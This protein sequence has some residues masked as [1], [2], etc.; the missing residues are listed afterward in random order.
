MKHFYR[1]F[2]LTLTVL[3]FHQETTAQCDCAASDYASINVAGWVVGQTG[4]I[5]TCQWGEERST[6]YN[7]VAG[8]VYRVF[9]CGDGD[10]DTQL[11]IYTTGCGYIGY[12]DDYCGL[13]SQVTFTS[14]GGN[15]YSVLNRYY[16]GSQTTC[17]TVQIQLIS[18]PTPPCTVQGNPAVFGSNTWNVY[19]YDGNNFNTYQGYY[20]EGNLSFNTA[21]RWGTGG[22]PSSASGYQ[23]CPVGND[24]H[25]YIH[26]R[27]GFPAGFYTIDIGRDDDYFLYVNGSLIYSGGCCGTDYGIWSGYLDASS[28]VEIRFREYGG[29]SYGAAT[30]NNWL[31]AGTLYSPAN[32]TT[33]TG[34]IYDYMGP[35][36][37]Y[38]NGSN[39]YTII[40]PTTAGG[41]VILSGNVNTEA[42]CD[43][44]YIYNGQGTGGTLLWS[45][46][47]NQTVP[48][49]I[50]TD[51][52]GALTVRFY[53]DGSVT[54]PGFALNINCCTPAGDQV[55]YGNN[56]W[57]FYCY[58]QTNFTEY[59]GYITE[60]ATFYE[61]FGGADDATSFNTNGCPVTRSNFSVR[62]RMTYNFPCGIYTFR[63]GGDDGHRLYLDGSL[64]IDSYVPQGYTDHYSAPI[65]LSGN[66]NLEI[67]YYEN[68][69]G[70]AVGF[71]WTTTTPTVSVGITQGASGVQCEGT[72]L[73]LSA[74]G[75]VNY[76][77]TP[78]YSWS[79][80]G[81]YTASGASISRTNAPAGTYTVTATHAC[82]QSASSSYVYSTRPSTPA[83]T[84][85]S[86][87]A[88]ICAGQSTTLYADG[89]LKAYY[90]FSSNYND[91]SGNGLHI[92]GGSGGTISAGSWQQVV[93]GARTTASTNIL[94][95]DKYTIEF[96]M[97]FTTASDGSWRKIFGF[98]PSGTDRSPGI[99][100]YPNSQQ[101]HWRHDPGNT[102]INEAFIYN[103]GQWYNVVGEKNGST[104]TLY[105]DGVQV[106]QG[107]VAN[108]KTVGLSSLWFGGA[109][110]RIKEFKVYSGVIRWYSGSCGGTYAGA[111]PQ[112]FVSPSSTTTYYVRV[113]GECNTSSCASQTVTVNTAPVAF[114]GNDRSQC[115]NAAYQITDATVNGSGS[116]NNWT[117]VVNSG[118]VSSVSGTNS[119]TPTITPSSAT[120]QVTMTLNVNGTG[121]CSNTSDVM[122]F[123]WAN[124]PTAN[125]GADIIQ[126]GNASVPFSGSS[127]SSP[128]TF[129]WTVLGGGSGS[130]TVTAFQ[131]GGA[132]TT[133]WR[134]NPTTASGS[135]TVRLSVT[136]TGLCSGSTVT[137]DIT[138]TW[139]EIPSVSTSAT[140]TSCTGDSPIV[141]SGASAGGTYSALSWTLTANSGA[142]SITAN[143]GTVSPT[144]TPD[145]DSTSG[146]YILT[147][148]ALG[149]GGCVGINP[150]SSTLLTWGEPPIAN[151]GSDIITCEG[152]SVTMTGST[153]SGGAHSGVIWVQT[154][155]TASGSFTTTD[156]IDP[157]LW[158]FTPTSSGT[159]TFELQ[160]TGSGAACASTIAT[161][162]RIVTWN[163][164]PTVNA[165]SDLNI[166]YSS[167][168][169]TMSG[170][171]GTNYSSYSWSGG[172][173]IF[174]SWNQAGN[175][176][177]ANFTPI[178][179]S[180]SFLAQVS[181]NGTGA[182]SAEV[183]TD[184]RLV[185]WSES[186]SAIAGT[187]TTTCGNAPHFMAGA[188]A[189]G[190]FSTVSWSGN[191]N[192][193]WTTTHATDPAQWVWTPTTSSGSFTS[194]LTVTG[195]GACA[196]TNPTVTRLI[197]WDAA[198]SVD[199]GTDINVCSSNG[200]ISMSG[201]STANINSYNWSNLN[202]ADGSWNQ[203]GS[204]PLA[205]FTPL[206]GSG[207]IL[208]TLT[209][210]GVGA[211]SALTF[212]DSRILTWNTPPVITSV[213]S[214]NVTDC[215]NDNGVI[216]INSTGES[217]F[218]Y[219]YDNGSTYIAFNTRTDLGAGNYNLV[220]MDN[221]GCTTSYPSNPVVI[222]PPSL[223]V[224]S[225]S[226]VNAQC[227][228]A[229]DGTI[230]VTIT[231]GGTAR[232]TIDVISSV[233]TY[234]DTTDAIGETATLN[235]IAGS[236]NITITDRFGCTTSVG[237][238]V[239][240]EPPAISIST[241]VVNNTNCTGTDGSITVNASGGTPGF[242]FSFDGGAFSATN[243]FTNLSTGDYPIIVRDNND[244][245]IP[246]EESIGGPF[247]ANA[248]LDRYICSGASFQMN[249]Q[250][251]V[252]AVTIAG[253]GGWNY[254]LSSIAYNPRTPGSWT[255]IS[256][257]DDQVSTAVAI[258]FPFT[259][260]GN[261]YTNLYVSSNGFL[262]F[263]N[264]G[265][266][267]C[268][269]GQ[270]LPNAG[271]P[272]NL[273][274]LCWEDLNPGYGGTIRYGVYGSSPNQVFVLEYNNIQHYGGGNPVT[275]QI[276]LF[277]S[278]NN[279][280]IHNTSVPTDG[281]NGHTQGI[282]NAVGDVSTTSHNSQG[283]WTETNS[284]YL[285]QPPYDLT[286][287]NYTWSPST[288]LSNPNILNPT[289]SGLTSDQTYTLQVEMVGLCTIV[290]DMTVHV[291]DLASE[292]SGT[293]GTSPNIST[294]TN[295][296]CNGDDDGCITVTPTSGEGPYLLEG[297]NGEV[298]VYGGRM[299]EVTISN[300]TGTTLTDYQ[301]QINISYT[302]AMRAD[303]GDIRFYDGTSGN[304][305]SLL[306]YY[307]ESYSLSS[308]ANVFVKLPSI[309]NGGTTVYMVYGN[310][311]LVSQSDPDNTFWWYEDMMVTPT[312]TMVNNA[313]YIDHQFVRLTQAVNSASGQLRLISDISSGGDGF[314]ADFEFWIGGGDGADG[315]WL[316]S[317]G[318]DP[319][320]GYIGEDGN[321]NGYAFVFDTW[322]PGGNAN[323]G[324]F[325]VKK[326]GANYAT[327]DY[328]QFDNS[329]W[330][331][332]KVEQF[333][334]TGRMSLDGT[335]YVNYTGLPTDNVGNY[336]GFAA[337]TGGANNEHRIRNIRVR[338]RANPEPTATF[339]TEQLPDN[340]FC[341]LAPGSYSISIWDIAECT[342][343][344]INIPITEPTQ[345][346][347]D[348]ID[349]TDTWCY[350]TNNGQ[351]D[352]TVSG[353]TQISPPPPYLYNWAGPSGFTSTNEDLTGLISGTYNVTV[354]DD[355][356]CTASS[357]AVVNTATP[358]S[359]PSFT[360]T[361]MTDQLWQDP[362]NWDCGVPDATSDVIIPATPIGGNT[363][364]IT[365][366]IIGDVFHI[367]VMG[368]IADLLKIDS[369][370]GSKLR[371]HEP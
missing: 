154:G 318:D 107:T 42:C 238:Y 165:S 173:P 243:S 133:D 332:A 146:E 131:N 17:M 162:S 252:N 129:T 53:T 247:D 268:C 172:D 177:G 168:A 153:I 291:S 189:S 239:I 190:T 4:T 223:P 216:T 218:Q 20:T 143:G 302:G 326:N 308:S 257:G 304:L 255:G 245:E 96:D 357:S 272:N 241:V 269:T 132:N 63:L 125:A 99:W 262:S 187:P 305:G 279:I 368:N 59:A 74:S 204:A 14:P 358:I 285:F 80:P 47:G 263:T 46:S 331:V 98:T 159:A 356:G 39:G 161:D 300:S 174:G 72:T 109:Q 183:A 334:T 44:L 258:T 71:G 301:V 203:G 58:N 25:S 22:T 360:W 103:V 191:P 10:F 209:V 75:S 214:T 340:Q 242:T 3:S 253:S 270:V 93:G 345:L 135:K 261:T 222:S 55:S 351:L 30:F 94:N 330:R 1:F 121:G 195:T 292:S 116:L 126:C 337:R 283:S 256:L 138:V 102:G 339:G 266:S 40:N 164:L 2:V 106:A 52:T 27:Q 250:L 230:E 354:A 313:A 312:G 73:S 140:Q 28:T 32:A 127:A 290:D 83:P 9:T 284:A 221:N 51:A 100:K 321:H 70:N 320:A 19:V 298:Q 310:S 201:A 289:V 254:D 95:T 67:E 113:E 327:F 369:T 118:T 157:T 274:A 205:T 333:N 338:K 136:G 111:G 299:K 90:P 114:A 13:Q 211:C 158:I 275:G 36:A 193:A 282:E 264:D 128:S 314:V 82:G 64:I 123:T 170:A 217:P 226:T 251:D 229:E 328:N 237:P 69:G 142:G 361:G 202:P 281:T 115:S 215:S 366:G 236:Y 34:A 324:Q 33:C 225:V 249:A 227:N 355:N 79:G 295:V 335:L 120:G 130:G 155:G 62:G 18:L 323:S 23:G 81:G 108:P 246:F 50:S 319:G 110:V 280:E 151:A 363:P 346:T 208:A 148:T 359:V 233:K 101:L 87:T 145:T 38:L 12:N 88:T 352:I 306:S 163:S 105:I 276:L 68:G 41:K 78:T 122:V 232:Y 6:I 196:G 364:L 240:S 89:A 61:D 365:G 293:F 49:I 367:R 117:Y 309:P 192:G 370:T 248:G 307:V 5:T 353:G 86:G 311:S 347:I 45:G 210:D 179:S 21:N 260:Y 60:A 29:G 286:T 278:T 141:I 175:L 149:S 207:Q 234:S 362:T 150:S 199:A 180:G 228:G 212:S 350:T 139:S 224:V 287:I 84:G 119:L 35:S 169:I 185:T 76:G 265:N 56:A 26:K 181:V 178:S 92:T 342:L 11:S 97:Q 144:F 322:N 297:P 156:P 43:Y 296:A 37:D 171:T 85:I 7:T 77:P 336:F 206:A 54:A 8:A 147:L 317:D 182:C 341:D 104:L 134:F 31:S 198:P 112:L 137:D 235:V 303:F 184:S 167:G 259:F 48:Q 231:S 329:T 273:V 325:Q 349:V 294:V 65:Y 200:A 24:Q 160:V 288:G 348:N 176:S 186:P 316:Y 194:T 197:T 344:E 343:T 188:S 15:L 315:L 166:C 66:H 213:S 152:Y 220:V 244:C 16:C 124:G 57:N 271:S 371:V 91:A 277:E 219:S 267:G